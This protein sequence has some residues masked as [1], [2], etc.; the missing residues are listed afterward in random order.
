VIRK[1]VSWDL[2]PG[3]LSPLDRF[4]LVDAAG[5]EGVE[6]GVSGD[7]AFAE[8]VLNAAAATG[9]EIHSVAIADDWSGGSLSSP[10]HEVVE[11]AVADALRALELAKFWGAGAILLV[12]AFVDSRTSYLEAE[13]RSRSVIRD[14]ILPL[15]ESLGI[16][17]GIENVL[18]GSL[19]SPVDF[20]RYVDEFNSPFV[21]AYLDIGN[22]THGHPE[23]W[24]SI[25]DGRIARVH[26][27]DIRS[28]QLDPPRYEVSWGNFGDGA[29]DWVAVRQAFA[30]AGY[31]G[32]MTA[33]GIP[34]QGLRRLGLLG[35][36]VFSRIHARA[37]DPASTGMLRLIR[38]GRR[39]GDRAF[40]REVSRRFDIFVRGI[41]A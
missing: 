32:F 22:C 40:L 38:A 28:I 17:V 20:A 10:E 41:E 34:S 13:R 26:V 31:E 16:V 5:F 9:I 27:K 12:P 21:Q 36:S 2:L 39:R 24:I 30:D 8:E 6:I 35:D 25:L 33:A 3:H 37:G 23:H 1:A 15:A 29:I 11:R 7:P 19:L 14:R 4:G 18:N